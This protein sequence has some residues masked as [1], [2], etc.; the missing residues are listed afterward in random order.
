MIAVT[1]PITLVFLVVKPYLTATSCHVKRR[2]QIFFRQYAGGGAK[3]HI[4]LALNL[5]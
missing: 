5:L 2:G 3:R 4:D 1:H